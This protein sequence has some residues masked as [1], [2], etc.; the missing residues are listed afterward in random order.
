[1]RL[2][3]NKPNNALRYRYIINRA[4]S[5]SNKLHVKEGW[6]VAQGI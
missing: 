4:F 5:I 2:S 3:D 6:L 1:M